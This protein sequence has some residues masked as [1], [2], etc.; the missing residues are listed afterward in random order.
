MGV[1][2]TICVCLVLTLIGGWRWYFESVES[3]NLL[4]NRAKM[5][6]AK[7]RDLERLGLDAEAG[8]LPDE[9]TSDQPKMSLHETASSKTTANP[10]ALVPANSVVKELPLQETAADFVDA[11]DVI[12]SFWKATTTRERLAFVYDAPRVGPYMQEFYD[13]LRETDPDHTELKQKSRLLID[14]RE[15]LYFGYASSRPTGL[16]ELALRRNSNGRFLVDW[17]SLSGFSGTSFAKIRETKPT[18]PVVVRAFVRLF[19][20]YNYEFTDA[21]R[22]LCVKLIASNGVDT[23]YGYTERESEIGIWLRTHLDTNPTNPNLSGFTLKVSFPENAQSD[24]CM[25]I[26]QVVAARWLLLD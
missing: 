11:W 9:S 7:M 14:D 26:N 5:H 19:E 2:A 23:L 24:Q 6:E 10:N 12:K 22:Y 1:A 16:C 3:R 13:Q 21:K 17:E 18:T 4:L 25:N 15:I 20:Y 8:I